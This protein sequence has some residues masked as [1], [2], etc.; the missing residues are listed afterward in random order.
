[1]WGQRKRKM[2]RTYPFLPKPEVFPTKP[3][4]PPTEGWWIDPY[5]PIMVGQ[6]YHDG[7]RWTQYICVRTARQWTDVFESPPP[8]GS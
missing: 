2:D 7:T 4:D 8:V 1:M 6:R 5:E 3:G